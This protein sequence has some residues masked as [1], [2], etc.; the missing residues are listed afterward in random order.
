MATARH[1]ADRR[2]RDAA[3]PARRMPELAAGRNRAAGPA[4]R[5]DFLHHIRIGE[6]M[7]VLIGQ[8]FPRQSDV[9]TTA[10]LDMLFPEG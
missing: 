2:V 6:F 7:T 3:A 4:T 1:H 8:I 9:I 10:D 5:P